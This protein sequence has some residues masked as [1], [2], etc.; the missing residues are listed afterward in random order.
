MERFKSQHSVAAAQNTLHNGRLRD[1]VR[2]A[3]RIDAWNRA[4][5]PRLP[6][7]LRHQ[8]RLL[9]LRDGVAVFACHDGLGHHLVRWHERQLRSLLESA[10][11]QP[12]RTL[13]VR[14]VQDPL[15]QASQ[16]P[17]QQRA[18]GQPA[19]QHLHRLA[20]KETDPEW[21]RLLENLASRS[22]G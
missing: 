5:E 2:H 18:I 22:G 20:E 12:I 3:E 14:V 8:V 19:R 9:N 13:Q 21:R 17:R 6:D 7:R 4:I 1:L 11:G 16:A 15:K 10:C